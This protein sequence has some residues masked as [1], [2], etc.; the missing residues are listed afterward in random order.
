MNLLLALMITASPLAAA[1]E[2]SPKPDVLL[3][4]SYHPEFPWTDGVTEGLRA[5]LGDSIEPEGLRLEYMDARRH[6]DDPKFSQLTLSYLHQKYAD[7]DLGLVVVSDEPAFEFW[8]DHGKQIAPSVPVVF[9]GVNVLA[10]STLADHPEITG[11][12]EG[13]EIEKNLALIAQLQPEPGRLIVLGDKTKLGQKMVER[14]NAKLQSY[15]ALA[16]DRNIEVWDSFEN[17]ED[18]YQRASTLSP[19]DAI[20]VLAVHRDGQGNY[21]SYA[22]HLE[23]LTQRSQAPVY[24]MW[25]IA[26][27]HGVV[28]G[29]VNDPFTHGQELGALG[30]KLLQGASV[31]EVPVLGKTKYTP[32]FDR[33][34]LA[35]YKIK[36]NLLPKN[37]AFLE[38]ADPR[39]FAQRQPLWLGLALLAG[40]FALYRARRLI[41]SNKQQERRVNKLN[42]ENRRLSRD[43]EL[44]KNLALT[45]ELTGIPNRRS[46]AMQLDAHCEFAKQE[47]SFLGQASA[48]A[49][50]IVDLDHFK[51]VNDTFGHDVG[52][53]VLLGAAKTLRSELRPHDD[54]CRWGGEEFLLVLRGMEPEELPVILNRIRNALQGAKIGQKHGVKQLTASFGASLLGQDCDWRNCLERADKALYLAKDEGRNRVSIAKAPESPRHKEAKAK[55]PSGSGPV[56]QTA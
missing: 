48:L 4:H 37:A 33:K 5:A 51:A 36:R 45:D 6:M 30:T 26:M 20:L 56:P 27:G 44:Y 16:N 53:D 35:R 50:A 49:I 7:E 55:Q 39:S 40:M 34:A 24:S 1:P 23:L 22:K 29:Y 31:S 46:G 32:V 19:E 41:D 17:F 13:M 12:V 14:V 3:L 10:P 42:K 43:S 8:L 52:D 54:L 47:Q 25:G 2:T 15:E 18:L 11:V 28:G 9:G 38:E 21:W